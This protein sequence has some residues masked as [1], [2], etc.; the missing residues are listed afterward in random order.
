MMLKSFPGEL[1]FGR[2]CRS[3]SVQ[4]YTPRQFAASLCLSPG[5]SFHPYLTTNLSNIAGH[6]QESPEELWLKQT[7]FPLWAWSMPGYR[8]EFKQ[9]NSSPARLL[10]FCQLTSSNEHQGMLLRFCPVCAR[11]DRHQFGIA[12]WH[13]EHQIPGISACCRHGCRLISKSV[14][15]RPHIALEFYPDEYHDG[16]P[17]AN[18]E[19]RFS[20]YA[21]GVF[22]ELAD[23]HVHRDPDLSGILV[24]KGYLNRAGHVRKD[25]LFASLH[26]I[27]H[28]LWNTSGFP[29]PS[30]E[31]RFLAG[32][33][34]QP[35]N[36]FPSRKLLAQ[37]C[38]ENLAELPEPRRNTYAQ[39]LRE[40]SL[41]A[42]LRCYHAGC[43]MNEISRRT[44]R[45]RCYIKGVIRREVGSDFTRSRKLTP[46]IEAYVVTMA[47]KGFHRRY[48]AKETGISV[49]SVETI[50]SGCKGLVQWRKRCRTES[51]RRRSRFHVLSWMRNN[52]EGRR[53]DVKSACSRHFYWLYFNDRKWFEQN[54][55]RVEARSPSGRVNWEKRDIALSEK[56]KNLPVSTETN[57]SMA[58][59]DATIGARGAISRYASKLPRTMQAINQRFNSKC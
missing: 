30:N 35:G 38:A 17:C 23:G 57:I 42:I 47:R 18:S 45:S 51:C 2:L 44:G 13:C 22:R 24:S 21:C 6:C 50:I 31:M 43:S 27:V 52:P 49:G 16:T 1:L 19:A 36:I 55:P 3:F 53:K 4:G 54:L 7:L 20:C 9:L 10:R 25:K 12:Y 11:E 33:V 59:L 39:P 58:Y 48:I 34:H 15:P 29:R 5:A 28:E 41:A 32:L 26:A 37:Y 40:E 56:V 8:R 46:Q 14:P